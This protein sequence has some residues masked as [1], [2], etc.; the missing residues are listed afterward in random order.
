M[1]HFYDML[2]TLPN[3]CVLSER[4]TPNTSTTFGYAESRLLANVRLFL[5]RRAHSCKLPR[6]LFRKTVS[7]GLHLQGC[8]RNSWSGWWAGELQKISKHRARRDSTYISFSKGGRIVN[9]VEGWNK[10]N[11]WKYPKDM[12][13]RGLWK[14]LRRPNFRGEF[15][16]DKIHTQS[17]LLGCVSG[18]RGSSAC[19]IAC[20]SA[21][22]QVLRGIAKQANSE[23]R[24]RGSRR[25]YLTVGEYCTLSTIQ[26]GE[27]EQNADEYKHFL[28]WTK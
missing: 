12:R 17:G 3:A 5:P 10:R 24:L 20:M 16:G 18:T 23:V 19:L 13:R 26:P 4:T 1:W 27:A 14:P 8:N 11:H 15:K 25:F 2:N 7:H 28:F 21:P 22:N 6:R 9:P